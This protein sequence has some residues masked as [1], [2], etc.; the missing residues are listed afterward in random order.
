MRIKYFLLL[1]LSSVLVLGFRMP[2]AAVALSINDFE[3]IVPAEGLTEVDLKTGVCVYRGQPE[4]PV[5]VS[6][7]SPAMQ[8]TAATII[9]DQGEQSLTAKQRVKL[10][11][12]EAGLEVTGERL[13]IT[14]EQV[15]LPAG[16]RLV[17][18]TGQASLVSSGTLRYREAEETVQV[19]GG[20][21]LFYDDLSLNGQQLDGNLREG[22]FTARG[23]LSFEHPEVAGE[24][25]R[26]EYDQTNQVITLIGSPQLRWAEGWL[27]GA[28]ETVIIYNFTTGKAKAEGPTKMRVS[29]ETVVNADGD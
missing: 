19:R 14:G 5:R 7:S 16:G 18:T 28:Q 2:E 8:L 29:R 21:T 1:F 6:V 26:I 4:R 10:V 15:E 25:E 22:L 27:Q 11:Q 9:Y 20:F 17:A 12:E 3:V 13:V 23:G 24:A